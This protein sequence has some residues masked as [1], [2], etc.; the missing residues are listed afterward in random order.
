MYE[1]NAH[2]LERVERVTQER[3]VAQGQALVNEQMY[4]E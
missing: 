1:E 3:D 2:L 4:E